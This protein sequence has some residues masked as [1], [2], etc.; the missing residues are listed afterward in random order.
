MGSCDGW[1]AGCSGRVVGQWVGGWGGFGLG[2]DGQGWFAWDG[3]GW[4]G[5]DGP[6]W[7][8]EG[9]GAVVEQGRS[10]LQSKPR[11]RARKD[12]LRKTV[13]CTSVVKFVELPS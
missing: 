5:Q 8:V 2:L 1:R 11:P 13:V 7:H 3:L 9:D 6:K 10:P 4:D 12:A